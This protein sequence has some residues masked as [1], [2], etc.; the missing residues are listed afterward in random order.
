MSKIDSHLHVWA[1][2]SERY[3]YR[4]GGGEP[5]S[6][7][8]VEYLM[9]LLEEAGVSGAVIVQPIYH[10]FDH[11]YVTDVLRR[12]PDQFVGMALA[13]PVAPDS[14]DRLKRLV[15]EDGYRGVRINPNL[16]PHTESLDGAIGYRL[17]EYCAEARIAAGFLIEPRHFPDVSALCERFPEVTTI[18][19]HFG[20]VRPDAPDDIS[21]L[22]GL[23]K[24]QNSY[25]KVSGFPVSSH[26][27]WPYGDMSGIV[28]R[29]IEDYGPQR[30]MFATDFPHIVG[31]CGYSRGWEIAD[32]IT[33]S[34]DEKHQNWIMSGTVSKVFGAWEHAPA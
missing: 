22:I 3:P 15:E 8:D 4:P 6:R 12:Y 1:H 17:M 30:L 29:L 31:Q 34:L 2:D 14:V 32:R 11:S 26:Q 19:D 24:H 23:S 28:H 21:A 7:G 10:G 16:W 33:P 18:I 27:E 25:V 5:S 13:N 20:R 9:E